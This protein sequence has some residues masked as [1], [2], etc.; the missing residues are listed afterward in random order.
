MSLL[1]R[2]LPALNAKRVRTARRAGWLGRVLLSAAVLANFVPVAHAAEGAKD[3]A[4]DTAVGVAAAEGGEA[5][6]SWPMRV[7]LGLGVGYNGLSENNFL[8]NGYAPEDRPASGAMFAL[9][10]TAWVLDWLGVEAEGKFV[11]TEFNTGD[12]RGGS[13]SIFGIRGFALYQFFPDEQWRPFVGVGGG[14]ENYSSSKSQT[15]LAKD[16]VFAKDSDA[17]GV[18][19]LGGGV[20]YMPT[21]RLGVRLD[22]RYSYMAG[23]EPASA[24]SVNPVGAHGFETTLGLAYTLGGKPGDSDKDGILD[25]RDRCPEEAEDKD[26]FQDND[27]CPEADNDGDKLKDAEDKCP[28]EP[29]DMDGFED[30]D[31]CP[32]LDNDKD[33]IADTA[34][35]C[36]AQMEDKDGFEDDDGCPESDNDKDSILDGNDKCPNK[37]EDLD[38]FEDTD[39]CPEDDN[40]KDGIPDAADKCKNEPET[41][42]GF[43]DDDGCPDV[44]P[45]QDADGVPD[46]RDKCIDKPETKNGFQDDDGCPDELPKALKKFT[47]AIQGIEFEL[48]SAKILPKSFKVLDGALAVLQEFPDTKIEVGGHTDNNGTPEANQKLSLERATSVKDYFVSKGIA[49]ERITAVGYGQDKPVADNKTKKGQAKNRRIEF[50]LL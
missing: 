5:A 14:V 43:Q 40:D 18:F 8:G 6:E 46:S 36:P 7:D 16:K 31:G 29:E 42:N 23:A 30:F 3:A 39:G 2:P 27:G 10:A 32:D 15:E 47:G 12:G 4:A 21:H 20:K 50:R 13:A 38:G 33:G 45:D 11:P 19:L 44:D 17:D 48:G 37:A 41:K 1:R 34:D 28:N 26:G 25:N 49:A 22:L 9:R 35:R 24:T